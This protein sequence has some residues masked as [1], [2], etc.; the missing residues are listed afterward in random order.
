VNAYRR[1]ERRQKKKPRQRKDANGAKETI[2]MDFF[3]IKYAVWNFYKIIAG[4]IKY[5]NFYS[6]LAEKA[7]A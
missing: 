2:S 1:D 6:A 4:N 3:Y 7:G 5:F